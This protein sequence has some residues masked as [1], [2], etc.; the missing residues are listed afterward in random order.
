M[1]M[2]AELLVIYGVAFHLPSHNITCI[3]ILSLVAVFPANIATTPP[4]FKITPATN[5]G[6]ALHLD[7]YYTHL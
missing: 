6:L 2:R 5:L 3:A 4:S 7:Y 1:T